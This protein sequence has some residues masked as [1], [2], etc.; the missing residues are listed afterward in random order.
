MN[1]GYRVFAMA[2]D[3]K[4]VLSSTSPRK[5]Y[6]MKAEEDDAAEIMIYDVIGADW[7]GGITAKQFVEDLNNLGDVKTIRL[8]INSPGGDVFDG[9]AIYNA[10][11]SHKARIEVSIDGLAASMATVVAMAGDHISMPEN[12]MMMIHNPWTL[13]MGDANEM[14]KVADVLDKAKVGLIAAYARQTGKD[15]EEISKLMDEE[16][17]MTGK[18][19]SEKGFTDEMTE[20]VKLAAKFDLS[21]FRRPPEALQS[22]GIELSD[23]PAGRKVAVAR[24]RLA[25]AGRV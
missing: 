11:V 15:A 17:W 24:R 12:A 6:S 16:T 13:A 20:P 10:L 22:K 14:R 3:L 4:K 1:K 9:T 19:A 5:W 7:Y 21:G 23:E 25:L 8:R 18:E 2:V